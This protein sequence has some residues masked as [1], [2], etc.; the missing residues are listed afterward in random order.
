M[1]RCRG[2]LVFW[3]C[4][5][6]LGGCDRLTVNNFTGSRVQMTIAGAK[7][8]PPGSHLELWARDGDEDVVR[9]VVDPQNMANPSNTTPSGIDCPTVNG[10]VI[11]QTTAYSI[12]QAVDKNDPCLIDSD[13][14]LLTDA[15]AWGG[16]ANKALAVSMRI[17]ELTIQQAN[18]LFAMVGWDDNSATPPV[19][20][21]MADATTRKDACNAWWANSP[22]AAYTGNPI[23]LT[24]P[25]HGQLYGMLDFQSVSP[26]PSQILGGIEITS[27]FSLRDIREL[28]LTVATA[29][30]QDLDPAETDCKANPTK[31]RGSLFLQGNTEPPQ[32][33][34][35]HAT[36][37]SP[38]GGASG[39]AAIETRLD[40]DPVQ[41]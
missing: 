26:A 4:V 14:H 8:T 22:Y 25:I 10:V 27:N 12:V 39:T 28:F 36:L 34:I 13:G 24:A 17:D 2:A 7:A 18:P 33:G 9:L 11:C 21:P 35:F 3:S 38:T 29:K 20:D 31:C 19:I 32:N 37:T 16:D 6:L 5:A 15:S 23:Q 41:F 40:E 30:F 1:P